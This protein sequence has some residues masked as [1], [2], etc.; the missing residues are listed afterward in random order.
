MLQ[1]GVASAVI[2]ICD[3]GGFSDPA[4]AENGGLSAPLSKH[5]QYRQRR[6]ARGSRVP[7]CG[8]RGFIAPAHVAA[9]RLL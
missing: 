7:I 8:S 5:Q 1:R 6:P 9:L 3:F 4:I 2:D